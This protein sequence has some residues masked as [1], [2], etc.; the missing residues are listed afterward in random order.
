ML[1]LAIL[2]LCL[3]LCL[4]SKATTHHTFSS[5]SSHTETLRSGESFIAETPE[6]EYEKRRFQRS[7]KPQRH[8]QYQGLGK[9]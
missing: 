4:R 1:D 2:S 8:L 5:S 9:C 3:P 6:A 7:Y